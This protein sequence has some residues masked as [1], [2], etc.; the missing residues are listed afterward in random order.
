MNSRTGGF[1]A[2]VLKAIDNILTKAIEGRKYVFDNKDQYIGIG[3]LI[4]D[5][6]INDEHIDSI[7][8]ITDVDHEGVYACTGVY[9]EGIWLSKEAVKDILNNELKAIDKEI[10][11][12]K[13]LYKQSQEEL[14]KQ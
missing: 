12:L 9:S 4:S 7:E 1:I 10:E 6:K 3:R 8:S 13:I 11:S 2:D 14:M 5:N